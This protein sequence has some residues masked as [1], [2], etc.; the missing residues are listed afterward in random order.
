MKFLD[1]L[2]LI[3]S[4]RT[5][6]KY[7]DLAYAVNCYLAK[8]LMGRE[9]VILATESRGNPRLFFKACF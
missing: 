9:P 5:L 8:E 1:D 6:K 3:C 2:Y 7:L 4:H